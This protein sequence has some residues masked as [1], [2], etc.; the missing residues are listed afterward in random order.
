MVELS[1]NHLWN[2]LLNQEKSATLTDQILLEYYRALREWYGCYTSQDIPHSLNEVLNASRYFLEKSEKRTDLQPERAIAEQMVKT[3]KGLTDHDLDAQHHKT[4]WLPSHFE[5]MEYLRN[6][7]DAQP[8]IEIFSKPFDDLLDIYQSCH[9]RWQ[10]LQTKL[11]TEPPTEEHLRKLLAEYAL[12][13]R[14]GYAPAHELRILEWA[15]SQDAKR[16]ELLRNA[17]GHGPIIR[18]RVLNPQVIL[19]KRERLHVEI[20]NIGGAVAHNFEITL[21][22]SQRFEFLLPSEPIVLG[23]FNVRRPCRLEWDIRPMGSPLELHFTYRYHTHDGQ[24]Q[25]GED[26]AQINASRARA[27]GVTPSGGN[28]YQAGTPVTAKQFYGRKKEFEEIV[29][30]LLAGITQPMLLR[31][32]RRI[33]KSSI[34]HQIRYVLT[35]EGE[36]Q[37]IGF[38]L[39][40]E[41]AL[42]KIHPVLTSL[43][44]IPGANYVAR[45]LQHIYMDICN[46]LGIKY[47]QQNIEDEFNRFPYGAFKKHINL[48]FE[49]RPEI[50]LLVMIDEWDEQLHLPE[51]G[52]SLRAIMQNEDRINWVISSTWTLKAEMGR[53]GSPFYGQAKTM[54]LKEMD[55]DS[56]SSLII[57]PSREIGADWHGDAIVALLEQTG[58]RPYLIQ[59]LCQEI[60]NY[61]YH[62]RSSLV[63]SETVNIALSEIIKSPQ[64]S[65]QP[66]SF[67][68]ED[69]SSSHRGKGEARLHWLGRLILWALDVNSPAG[70][71]YLEIKQAIQD[72][73]HQRKLQI[74]ED[75]FGEEFH[76]QM[77]ELEY[78]F[79]AITLTGQHY[80]FSIP[81]AQ[82]W[83]HH[84][85]DQHANP[86]QYAHT[87]MMQ[88]YKEWKQTQAKEKKND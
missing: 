83:F 70:L 17:L 22:P 10:S 60:I 57:E 44:E 21:S 33:G 71:T 53:F 47:G 50:R 59:F 32:A 29:Y 37:R 74:P 42:R 31:G 3:V 72:R 76:E 1:Y 30:L 54:E 61:L 52:P 8:P 41:I 6:V 11:S 80:T 20:E 18:V 75:F 85:I 67:L 81:L 84:M 58:R 26:D 39:D 24:K 56:A 35:H 13:Q 2:C 51:L 65:G 14:T 48:V 55:W 63:D 15:C 7:A 62:Q 88:D 23:A 9:A 12:L 49:Q 68:W 66:F 27:A 86:I 79:D 5:V 87:G 69:E 36:L 4:S 40:N 73:L 38:S 46:A 34:L 64:T 43:Q 78:I 25:N 28:P 82:R 77:I 19:E 16:I 45:W